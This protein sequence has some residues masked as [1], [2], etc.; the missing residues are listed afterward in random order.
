MK[1]HAVAKT[2]DAEKGKAKYDERANGR[3]K[4][5][6][7]VEHIVSATNIEVFVDGASVGTA[8]LTLGTVEIELDTKTGDTVP[9]MT[10]ASVV[11]VFNADTDTMTLTSE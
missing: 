8:A 7:E 1:P 10:E 4:L 2:P 6:V 3:K 9:T 11:E 5:N